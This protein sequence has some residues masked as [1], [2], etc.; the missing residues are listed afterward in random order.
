[1][2]SE[3]RVGSFTTFPEQLDAQH[4]RPFTVYHYEHSGGTFSA[5]FI[6]MRTAAF[7][8]NMCTCHGSILFIHVHSAQGETAELYCTIT[9]LETMQ[10][11]S[12]R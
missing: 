1:M 9:P 11:W 5:S 12:L 6:N 4:P 2:L 8:L 3:A 7:G 10:Q